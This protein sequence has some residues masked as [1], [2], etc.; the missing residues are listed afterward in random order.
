MKWLLENRKRLI[1][2]AELLSKASHKGIIDDGIS[3]YSREMRLIYRELKLPTWIFFGFMILYFAVY[4]P[5][6]VKKLT[7][8]KIL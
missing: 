5:V 6:L 3:N 8:S 7:G 2:Q 1:K 4:F